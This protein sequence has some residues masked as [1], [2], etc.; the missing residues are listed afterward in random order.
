MPGLHPLRAAGP[1]LAAAGIALIATP[2]FG[3][4]VPDIWEA[5]DPSWCSGPCA[6]APDL[7][8]DEAE[9]AEGRQVVIDVLANDAYQAVA[10]EPPGDR[11]LTVVGVGNVTGT[12][13]D[14]VA[15]ADVGTFDVIDNKVVYTAPALPAGA[16]SAD[17]W[18][19][20]VA[21]DAQGDRT[22]ATGHITVTPLAV[23]VTAGDDVAQ[24]PFETASVLDVTE[25]D[26][27]SDGAAVRVS[28]ASGAAHGAVDVTAGVLTY[29]PAAGYIG[30]DTF[31]YTAVS[32]AAPPVTA[33]V[34][35][36]VQAPG[37][38]RTT[39]DDAGVP[40]GGSVAVDVLAN[41][42]S[43]DGSGLTVTAAGGP[44]HG[45]VTLD[46]GKLTYTAAPGYTGADEFTYTAT[47]RTGAGATGTVRV[48]VAV[49]AGPS[50]QSDRVT[51][52]TAAGRG[53]TLISVLANDT[54]PVGATLALTSVTDGAHGTVAIEGDTAVYTPIDAG[55]TGPDTFTYVVTDQFG[56]AATGTVNVDVIGDQAAA[57]A[58]PGAPAPPAPP[59]GAPAALA[60]AE[61]PQTGANVAASI[62][63]SAGLAGGGVALTR[64]R[65][66]QRWTPGRHT[67]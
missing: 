32:D 49:P 5:Y 45:T 30:P 64:A 8:F 50:A 33:T 28:A 63:L 48:N 14:F 43:F 54:S 51:M 36:T 6:G 56:T 37:D 42:T 24:V 57:P 1:G 35:V 26:V 44:G 67:R 16:E 59:A 47:D 40:Y 52:N 27:S 61:L 25:N 31:T 55:Y 53:R 2:A 15:L 11:T 34:T 4:A 17:I 60:A 46:A 18:F 3:A 7:T 21:Q 41:D 19:R 58:V 22:P 38:P 10:G 9:V 65:P 23:A 62:A 20:Y 12:G 66:R 29:T 39:D 13:S